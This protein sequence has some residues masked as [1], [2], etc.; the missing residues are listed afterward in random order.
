MAVQ[1]NLKSGG[2]QSQSSCLDK[3][4]CPQDRCPDFVIRRHDT[5]PPLKILVEDCN[6]PF[7]LQGLVIEVNMW[8]LARLKTSI[9]AADT[10]FRLADDIGF[11]QIMVG[12]IIVFD[13]ARLPE[14]ML[15]TAFD[16]TNKLVQVQRGYHGTT[17]SAW[18]KGQMMRIFRVLNA[19]AQAEMVY[20]DIQQVDGTTERDV[21]VES[22]LVYE[23]EPEDTCLAGCYWLEFKVLKMI[24]VVW[25]LPG[26]NWEGEIHTHVDG[27]FYTGFDHSDSS[28]RLSFDQIDDKYYLSST[29]WPGLTHLHSDNNYYTGEVHNDGSVILTKTGI[30]SGDEVAYDEEGVVT[31]LDISLVPS[32]TDES[33]TPYYFGCILGE[34]VE[35]ARRFPISGEGFLIKVENSPTQEQL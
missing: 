14:R 8:A 19:P 1:F 13:R 12:D 11:E 17:A 28:V 7:D 24:D 21:L 2:C 22:Y 10:Y 31:A 30:P 16:E 29:P 25:Y 4:G 26:G 18:G 9:T 3:L 23:W 15:V 6:G 33:L 35:W 27:F 34:G 20:Q 32:F 5:K